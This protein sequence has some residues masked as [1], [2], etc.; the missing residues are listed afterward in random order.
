[1]APS[2]TRYGLGES[3]RQ[4]ASRAPE[5]YGGQGTCPVTGEKLGSRG[6]AVRVETVAGTAEKPSLLKKCLP[7]NWG[8]PSR[9]KGVAIYVCCPD[10]AARVRSDPETY[11]LKVIADRGGWQK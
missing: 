9:P 10:C 2:V 6:P 11:L 5:P 7:W 3:D 8:T 1:M 4:A